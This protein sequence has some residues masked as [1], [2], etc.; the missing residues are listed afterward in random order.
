MEF[1]PARNK[2]EAVARISNLTDSGPEVLGPGSKER[3]TVLTNLAIGLSLDLKDEET[4][5]ETAKRIATYLRVAWTP[6]CESIGQTITLKGLNLLLEHSSKHLTS[7]RDKNTHNSLE[8]ETKSIAE[9]VE[10]YTPRKMDGFTAI[11]EMKEAE[12][13]KWSQT[14][15]QGL[16]FEF[17][18]RPKLISTLGGA[19]KKIGKTEFDYVLT[20]PW[21]MKVHSSVSQDGK[22]RASG[23][24]LNDGYSMEMAI[25]QNGLGLI[26]L[27]GVPNYDLEFTKWFKVFRES[28]STTEPRRLLKKEFTPERVDF[29]FI[30]NKDRF[31]ESLANKELSVFNQGPQQSGHARNYKYSLNLNRASASDLLIHSEDLN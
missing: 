1:V 21:D 10:Q 17:K 11:K 4:K 12:F 24:Q 15:W 23:C 30:P 29:F 26:I 6:D 13:S 7:F 5:Q 31:D 8:E 22:R 9:I 25:S 19:P 14:E 20:Y 16:Y 28:K 18:V 2:L 27:S 3:K